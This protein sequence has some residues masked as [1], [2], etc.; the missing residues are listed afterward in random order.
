M[1]VC[2]SVC[3]SVRKMSYDACVVD[4]DQTKV[5]ARGRGDPIEVIKFWC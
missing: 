2:V 3:P 1:C 4:V 5:F